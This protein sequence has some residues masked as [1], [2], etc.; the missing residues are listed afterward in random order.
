MIYLTNFDGNVKLGFDFLENLPKDFDVSKNNFEKWI[1]FVLNLST[2]E[3]AVAITGNMQAYMTIYEVEKILNGFEMLIDGTGNNEDKKFAHYSSEGFLRF[4]LNIF[5][6]M[7][8]S[9]WNCG[10]LRP[11]FPKAK[12][13]DMTPD[14]DLLLKNLK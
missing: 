4:H 9:M 14:S 10:L 11:N 8:V 1:P 6:L 12:L 2:P 13:L 7:A 5:T 3:S